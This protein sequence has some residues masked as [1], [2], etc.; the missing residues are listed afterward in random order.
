MFNYNWGPTILLLMGGGLDDFGKKNILQA[1]VCKKIPAQ[2]R[3][4]P[5]ISRVYSGLEE[6][7][8]WA[9]CSLG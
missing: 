1:H 5:K 9:R 7:F 4:P 2:D 6:K 3:G 8:C